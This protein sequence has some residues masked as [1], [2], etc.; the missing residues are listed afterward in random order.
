MVEVLD[1]IDLE[2]GG[3]DVTIEL[4]HEELIEFA[5]I[6]IRLSI[7]EVV[8]KE[9]KNEGF[10]RSVSELDRPVSDS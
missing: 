1:W 2:D 9:L 8:K 10:H 6:G 3:A 5:K 7:I 4:T